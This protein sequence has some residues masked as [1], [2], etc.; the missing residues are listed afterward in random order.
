[1]IKN[2][3]DKKRRTVI[4]CYAVFAAAAAV[5]LFTMP[6]THA[7]SIMV[8]CGIAAGIG[9]AAY[10]RSLRKRSKDFESRRLTPRRKLRHKLLEKDSGKVIEFPGPYHA[11]GGRHQ[12]K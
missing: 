12:K 10:S 7:A 9:T 3:F 2:Q 5:V 11:A 4:L 1:M 6:G 8:M